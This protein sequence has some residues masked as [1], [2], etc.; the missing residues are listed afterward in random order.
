MKYIFDILSFFFFLAL[1]TRAAAGQEIWDVTGQR[2]IS[3]GIL[4]DKLKSSPKILLGIRQDNPEHHD[5]A[6][7]VLQK[8]STTGHGPVIL[9]GNV[10]R[11]KQNAFAIFIQ[12]HQ[13]S[14]QVYDATGLDMLLD[15]AHSGQAGWT[16]ARPVFDLAMKRKLPLIASAFSRY[17]VGQIYINGQNGIPGDMAEQTSPRLL[18]P[19]PE[20]ARARLEQ[21]VGTNFCG[22]LPPEVL[23]KLVYLHRMQNGLFARNM[24][25]EGDHGT[26]LI[27]A[28]KYVDKEIGVPPMLEGKSISLIFAEKGQKIKEGASDF[29]WRA[30]AFP[31]RDPC[32]FLNP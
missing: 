16:N 12:R 8:L 1:L 26:L 9:V 14:G 21:E 4:I 5:L 24:T 20:G 18:Q 22:P 27:A 6:A 11:N 13:N 3:E 10:E 15:W 7:R 25:R 31:R 30:K 2:Y 28:Q 23:Q 32:E 29:I 17:E 19:L